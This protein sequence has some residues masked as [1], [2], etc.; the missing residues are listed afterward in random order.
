M[1]LNHTH[2]LSHIH[3]YPCHG[4]DLVELMCVADASLSPLVPVLGAA[5]REDLDAN[6]RRGGQTVGS[7]F[8][9]QVEGA[10]LV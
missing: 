5:I 4:A 9:Q 6:A 3:M 10:V 8:S 1:H 2:D 7:R